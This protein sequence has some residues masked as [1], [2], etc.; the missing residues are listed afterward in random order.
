MDE[1]I[2]DSCYNDDFEACY[3]EH[4]RSIKNSSPRRVGKACTA[5]KKVANR[6]YYDENDDIGLYLPT[7]EEI[8]YLRRSLAPD[9]TEVISSM[10]RP[11]DDTMATFF[12][13]S[14]W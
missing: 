8:I 9:P 3:N 4:L 7:E 14:Q 13:E 10:M 11:H 2:W 6:Y 1:A 5:G 12:L